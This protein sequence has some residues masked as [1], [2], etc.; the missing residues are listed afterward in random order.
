V[1]VLSPTS[2][3]LCCRAIVFRFVDVF[4]CI[5]FDDFCSMYDLQFYDFVLRLEI[6]YMFALFCD[7]GQ[8]RFFVL[9]LVYKFCIFTFF[10]GV[11]YAW[12]NL[13]TFI[14]FVT[15]S[16]VDIIKYDG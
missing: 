4:N 7:Y 14:Y 6:F 16:F 2:W 9:L 13:S 10:L 5:R 8:S 12:S 1:L 11:C 3:A 15:F